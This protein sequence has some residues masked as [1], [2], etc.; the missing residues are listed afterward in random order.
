VSAASLIGSLLFV[1][2]GH[3]ILGVGWTLNYE[4]WFY[5]VFACFLFVRSVR[6]AVCL[7]IATLFVGLL[8]GALSPAGA[9]PGFFAN[10]ISIEFCYGLAIAVIYLLAKRVTNA[11]RWTALAAGLAGIALASIYAP[12]TTT[13]GLE[14]NW[15]FLAWGIPAALIVFSLIECQRP[16]TAAGRFLQALGDSSY[17]LYLTH[18]ILMTIFAHIIRTGDLDRVNPYLVVAMVVTASVSVGFAAYHFLEK[19]IEAFAKGATPGPISTLPAEI[20]APVYP[21][22]SLREISSAPQAPQAKCAQSGD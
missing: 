19:R 3:L 11:I 20:R 2:S 17:S 4:M 8:L 1:D 5:L 6:V 12:H 7:I 21:F 16:K 15:R 13:A 22:S 9:V 18:S 14:F 10:P